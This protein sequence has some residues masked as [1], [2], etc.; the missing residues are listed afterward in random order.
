MS[1]CLALKFNNG[2]RFKCRSK[3]RATVNVLNS[4]KATIKAETHIRSQA[5]NNTK[6]VANLQIDSKFSSSAQHSSLSAASRIKVYGNIRSKASKNTTVKSTITSN[7]KI[8][9]DY[10]DKIHGNL[11]KIKSI[12][13]FQ[14]LEKLFPINDV[15]TS[16]NGNF[17]VNEKR[18][19]QLYSSIDEG[20]A[21]GN[22]YENFNSSI[23]IADDKQT[24]IQPSSLYTDGTFR[25]TC[26]V[27]TPTS[28]PYESFLYLRASAPISNYSANIA[29]LYKLYNIHLKD[30]SGNIIIEYEDTLVMGDAD[31]SNPQDHNFTTYIIN[32]K[33]NNTSKYSEDPAAPIFGS[34]LPYTLNLDLD[35]ICQD[36]SFTTGFDKGFEEFGCN[37]DFVEDSGNNYLAFDGAPF[38][39]QSLFYNINP[40]DHIR[41]TALEILNSGSVF[42]FGAQNYVNMVVQVPESGMRLSREILP[43]QLQ[44]SNFDTFIYPSSNTNVWTSPIT[45]ENN[46]SVSGCVALTNAIRIKDADDYITLNYV[47]D[48]STSG[49][50]IVKFSHEPPIPLDRYVDGA[51]NIGFNSNNREFDF[52]GYKKTY[53]VDSYFDIEE[54]YLKVIANKNIT[55]PN[56]AFDVVGYSNDKLLF[57]TPSVGGFLQNIEGSGNIPTVSGYVPPNDLGISNDS[58]S[59]KSE[60]LVRS[61]LI[62]DGGDHYLISQYVDPTLQTTVDSSEFKEYLVPLKIYT[63]SLNNLDDNYSLSSYFEN[64]YLDIYPIPSGASIAYMSLVVSYKPS[65]AMSLHTLGYTGAEIGTENTKLF[66]S[67]LDHTDIPSSTGPSFAPISNISSIPHG[68][69]FGDTLKTNYSRRWRGT[70]GTVATGPF[71][72]DEFDFSFYNPQLILPFFGGYY[73][74]NRDVGNTILSEPIANIDTLT[75]SYV[76]TYES[77]KNIG[78]RYKSASLFTDATYYT[79]IDWTSLNGY[80]NDPLYGKIADAFDTALKVNNNNQYVSFPSQDI[81]D[82][83]IIFTR[84]SPDVAMSGISHN[85]YNSGVIC[86]KYDSGN[87]LEFVLGFNNGHLTAHATDSNNNLITIQDPELYSNYSYPL[88]IALAYNNNNDMRLSLY[89]DN[90]IN[91]FNFTRLRDQSEVFTIA[92]GNSNINFGFSSGSGVGTIGY[93]TDI[94]IS[95]PSTQNPPRSLQMD[96]EEY[97]NTVHNKYW[98]SGE[99]YTNDTSTM[100]SYVD[101]DVDSW[102]LGAFKICEFN[103][104]FDRFT[105]RIGKDYLS[106]LAI[107]DGLAYSNTTDISIPTS[108]DSSC[109]YHTQIENDM[110]RL[111][112]SPKADSFASE[113]V[114]YAIRPRIVKSVVRDYDIFSEAFVVDTILEHITYNDIIWSNGQIG[115]KFIVSLYTPNKDNPETPYHNLGLINR[116]THYLA[117]SGCF[118]KISSVFT[119][120][121]LFNEDSEDWCKFDQSQNLT[122]FN[123]KYFSKDIQEMF[124]QYD[125]VY[126]SGNAYESYINI[127][128]VTVTLTEALHRA[129]TINNL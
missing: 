89:T 36:K 3:I 20:I 55:S 65:N 78:L 67:M 87:V 58:L 106:H 24:F 112:L 85:F 9:V 61:G 109:S 21:L 28:T 10:V 39:T 127:Y 115:P 84:F 120:E 48:I 90:E 110:L 111:P 5:T 2:A 7:S 54:V 23:R 29:P 77:V 70:D 18:G 97:L 53:E 47:D 57:V 101:K 93:L 86:S 98:A 56:Y 69:S 68:Y 121:D 124:L 113:N 42:G 76:G 95:I 49:K 25:Y 64:L 72:F 35:I 88:S 73:T 102:H 66:P 34:T 43:S 96:I 50:L 41:I 44:L 30:P 59:N 46:V 123:H 79:T 83:F 91:S 38:A 13:N 37:L 6:I 40:S 62:N 108:I 33:T 8:V 99:S 80:N 32:T 16:L 71:N 118:Q 103:L 52:A 15:T 45:N 19:T 63:Q 27:S 125:I 11:Q 122:E 74:F 100:W 107:N 12:P 126:P 129:R 14:P 31:Y 117:P 105:Q 92:T 51:F 26:Q 104:D 75:G 81:T 116:S 128:A 114:L 17:F 1:T 60:W 94:G 119:F 4:A 82:G 22:Y